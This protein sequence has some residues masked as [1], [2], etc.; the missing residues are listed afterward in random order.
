MHSELSG[1]LRN[2]YLPSSKGLMPVY[3]AVINSI[4]AIED[5]G[6]IEQKHL[7][8]YF[9]KLE[10]KRAEKL[11]LGLKP[12]PRPEGEII[13]FRV[14][15]NGVGFNDKNWES[16]KTL[17]SLHKA[18][19]GCRGI[20]RLMWLKA[21]TN[22]L[23]DSTYKENGEKRR[24][25][26]GFDV[27]NE[28]SESEAT[29]P[30]SGEITTVVELEG[31]NERFATATHKTSEKIASGLLEHCLWYFIRQEGVP[32]ITVCDDAISIDLSELFDAHMHTSSS[33]ET[34]ELKTCLFDITHV[35]VR[36]ARNKPH[37]LGYC[38]SG[39]LVR[40]ENLTGKIPG[41]YRAINDNEGQF[42]YMAYLTSD[43]LDK[44]VANERFHFNIAETTDGLFGQAEISF[45][46]IREAVFPRIAAYLEAYLEEVLSEGREKIDRFI[47]TKAP[48]YRPLIAHI[49]PERLSV[50]PDISDKELETLLHRETFEVEQDILRE[51]HELMSDS[52][53]YED[54][55]DRLQR[56]MEKV[57]DLRQSDLANY[58]ANRRVVIDLLDFA[59]RQQE[60]GKFVREDVIHELIVP[61]RCAS[62]DVEYQR[63]NLWLVDERLA[64]HHFLASDLPLK[65]NP[66]TASTSGREPDIASIRVF[67][68]PLLIGEQASQQASITVVEIKRPMRKGY[69]AGEGEDKDPILQSLDY[70]RRLREGASTVDGRPI[71]NAAKIPGF[72]YVLA[73]LT[74]S[75][76]NCCRLHQLQI[77]ADGMGY[78]GY[79]RDESYNAYI[80]VMSFD[81]LVESAK[82]RNR[83]FFD[84]LGLPS[85]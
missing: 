78:F 76:V 28:V 10:I 22:V 5:R 35:K 4:E 55:A 15:D 18:E 85:Q 12:G 23:V 53:G 62:T 77:T 14:T 64:F 63:Q 67:E 2:T 75:L 65:S 25:K 69:Q 50:D 36:V 51:G 32:Q 16:F 59:I 61:M 80:Q 38:A 74:D 71:P 72:V 19:K 40:E 30:G 1:R 58:V 17:D 83:A 73:D 43:Y 29:S 31:F 68:N 49:P 56:Y 54:Y 45:N 27:Q 13:G 47:A 66:T 3:E 7:S 20:G 39:R 6:Q 44:H 84:K 48:K 57:T 11:D 79:H 81:G 42:T 8:R 34:V 60:D 70:L 33:H 24:R 9:I 52:V 82:E 26:F 46:D 41:L 21:F 37:T